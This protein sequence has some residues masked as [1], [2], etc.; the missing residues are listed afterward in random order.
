MRGFCFGFLVLLLGGC[1]RLGAPAEPGAATVNRQAT[2][3]P[4]PDFTLPT[5]TADSLTL[6]SWRGSYVLLDFRA[7]DCAPCRAENANLRK[8]HQQFHSRGLQ[9]VSV[10]AHAHGADWAR[11]AAADSLRWPQ[12]LDRPT[13]PVARAYEVETRP[14]TVLLDPRGQE[15]ARNL[16]GRDL[17]Q[18]IAAYIPLD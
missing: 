3:P 12:V 10:W 2:R 11:V 16:F 15:L 17:G 1:Q 18:K 7:A 5:A 14:A 6:R 9:I 13:N 8:L 4:A